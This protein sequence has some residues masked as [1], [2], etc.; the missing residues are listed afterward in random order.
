[1]PNLIKATNNLKALAILVFGRKVTCVHGFRLARSEGRVA[2]ALGREW[3]W[4]DLLWQV[5]RTLS[6]RWDFFFNPDYSSAAGR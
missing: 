2:E 1:M 3:N 6:G 5:L 4:Q